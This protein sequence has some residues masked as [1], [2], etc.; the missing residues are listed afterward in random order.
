MSPAEGAPRIGRL[1]DK[2]SEEVDGRKTGN[3]H[4]EMTSTPE[5]TTHIQFGLKNQIGWR[6][7]VLS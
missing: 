1:L 7:L 5:V 4:R 6:I 2:E 3:R